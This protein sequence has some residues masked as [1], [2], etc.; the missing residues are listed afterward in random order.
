MTESIMRDM[1]SPVLDKADASKVYLVEPKVHRTQE[2]MLSLE[3]TADQKV[4]SGHL[5]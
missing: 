1:A 2:T 5:F 3:A 4:L